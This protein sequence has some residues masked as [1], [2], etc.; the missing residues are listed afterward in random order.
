MKRANTRNA[1]A[2]TLAA[3]SLSLWIPSAFAVSVLDQSN[4]A[5]AS[6]VGASFAAYLPQS[7][8]QTFTAG[9]SGQ[10]TGIGI[11][12]GRSAGSTGT[13]R[14]SILA[15]SSGV[16]IGTGS[17]LFGANFS[18]ANLPLGALK[19]VFTDLDISA[20]KISITQGVTYA[21]AVSYPTATASANW[22][23]WDM[24][25]NTY[26]GGR[27]FAGDGD[28]TTAWSSATTDGG[29][30]TF[31]DVSAVPETDSYVMMLGGCIVGYV[32]RR[33]RRVEV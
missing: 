14:F 22:L 2:Q 26:A 16:P 8:A 9:L 1:L 10:L 20:G 7:V 31:V 3:V 30:R 6:P 18:V 11:M 12:L 25:T 28:L 19:Y 23:T 17:E 27:A 5:G 21:I 33:R 13:F 15:T 32:I 29:F 24:S 4:D